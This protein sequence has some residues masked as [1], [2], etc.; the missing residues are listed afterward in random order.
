[1]QDQSGDQAFEAFLG[2][3]RIAVRKQDEAMLTSLM[4][5]DF[6]YRWDTPPAGESVFQYWSLNNLWPVLEGVLKQRFVANQLYMVAPAQV[7]ADPS[8]KGYRAGMRTVRGSWKFAYFVPGEGAR[9]DACGPCCARAPASRAVHI[10][11]RSSAIV[12][13]V[14]AEA[15]KVFPADEPF[16][17]GTSPG[18]A[19]AGRDSHRGTRSDGGTGGWPAGQRISVVRHSRHEVF[20]GRPA[21]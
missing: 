16:F 11:G 8:Y 3:L 20:A 12:P 4:T 19:A 14:S 17:R 13:G 15:R 21:R 2:R 18:F 9:S 1:M 5:P 7:V 6:G 10:R